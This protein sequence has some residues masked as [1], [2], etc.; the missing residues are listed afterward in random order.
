MTLEPAAQLLA[1]LTARGLFLEP[2]G[3]DTLRIG[4]PELLDQATVDQVRA[5]KPELLSILQGAG[6]RTWPCS[7]CGKYAFRLP[8]ICYWCRRAGAGEHRA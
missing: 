7:L 6:T 8:E 1:E 5:L 3:P 2:R 4:P